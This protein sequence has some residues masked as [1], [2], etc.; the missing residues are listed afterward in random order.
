[1]S[2]LNELVEPLKREVAV[3]GTFD[4]VFPD[5][6][7]SDLAATLADAMAEVQLDGFLPLVSVDLATFLTTPDISRAAGAL[8]TVYAGIRI[9]RNQI[10]NLPTHFKAEAQGNSF[11]RDQAATV[12][13]E[14]LKDLRARKQGFLDSA[15]RTQYA[16]TV[17]MNDGYLVRATAFYYPELGPTDG[18]IY[19][20]LIGG[21]AVSLEP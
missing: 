7:D 10:R 11:E 5:T 4:T 3:P 18:V 6:A 2:D 14:T 16:T 8:L 20:E 1:M 9:V 19:G 21:Y 17:R 13:T 15:K 12:F